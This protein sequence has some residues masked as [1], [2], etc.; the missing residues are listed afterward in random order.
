VRQAFLLGAGD[1]RQKAME[2]R[3]DLLCSA[4]AIDDAAHCI[5]DNHVHVLVRTAPQR[6]A[7]WSDEEVIRRWA[8]LHPVSLFFKAGMSILL[9]DWRANDRPDKELPEEV[10][11][12]LLTQPKLVRE[13]RRRLSDISW[14]MR[15][16][17]E[18]MSRH[19][20]R[21]DGVKGTF[22]E[23][24]FAS[25]RVLDRA[26]VLT[27]MAY[28]DLNPLR[29]AIV[30]VLKDSRYTTVKQRIEAV[31]AFLHVKSLVETRP[32]ASQVQLEQLFEGPL[33]EHG[34]APGLAPLGG[35]GT[36]PQEPLLDM[37]P[38]AYIELVEALARQQRDDKGQDKRGTLAATVV[39]TLTQMQLD[40]EAW[41]AA[42]IRDHRAWFGTAIGSPEALAREAVRRGTRRVIGAVR[43][44][45]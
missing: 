33:P 9:M 29:A 12:K 34:E 15:D 45:T 10:I 31:A 42:V 24:R 7:E 17:K 14:F 44:Y 3:L 26:G 20:N 1:D 21:E 5:M 28:I 27:C 40:V 36:G 37:D 18:P 13:L 25:Y 11:A 23:K 30:K 8:R 32:N 2:E 41:L 22:W 6:V 19:A 39:D 38:S 4:Y 16:L 35:A 43:V